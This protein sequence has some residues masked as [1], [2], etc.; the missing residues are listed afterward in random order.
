MM[1]RRNMWKYR[2]R[3]RQAFIVQREVLRRTYGSVPKAKGTLKWI[4]KKKP[5]GVQ[6]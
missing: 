4:P 1:G 2:A 3:E 5:H 6:A